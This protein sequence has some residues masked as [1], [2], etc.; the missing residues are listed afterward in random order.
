M[1]HNN[2]KFG[3]FSILFG[4][5]YG[6]L[7]LGYILF[8]ILAKSSYSIISIPSILL[9]FILFLLTILIIRKRVDIKNDRK[10]K[11]NFNFI[12]IMGTIPFFHLC[13]YVRNK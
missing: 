6:L 5:F 2:W 9:P 11:E 4:Y 10:A 12:I 7:Y 13:S 1:T 8:I 3:W